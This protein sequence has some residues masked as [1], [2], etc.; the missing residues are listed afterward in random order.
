ME[1]ERLERVRACV[2]WVN[3]RSPADL[4]QN[5]NRAPTCGAPWPLVG[6]VPFPVSATGF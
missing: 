4:G 3:R 6:S 2:R 1:R 5:M